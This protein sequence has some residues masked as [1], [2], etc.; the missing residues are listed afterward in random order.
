MLSAR[1][2]EEARIEGL[3][4][5][6][7]DYIVKPFTARELVA[8]VGAQLEARRDP[9]LDAGTRARG[10]RAVESEGRFNAAMYRVSSV[11]R[12]RGRRRA[13]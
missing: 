1:A 4:A 9:A 3:E 13:R 11:A 10:A 6:A 7:D 2:G 12:Q 8:R 5:G